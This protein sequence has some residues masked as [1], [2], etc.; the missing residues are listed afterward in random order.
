MG[1]LRQHLQATQGYIELGMFVEAANELECIAPEERV[2]PA[3]L[4]YRYAIYSEMGKWIMAEVVTRQMVKISPEDPVWWVNWAYATRRCQNIEAARQILLDAEKLHPHAA[5]QFNLA[6]YVC[7]IGEMEEAKSRVAAA[8]SLDEKFR[9]MA[10]DDP[11]L[12]PLWDE[13]ANG[14]QVDN[15]QAEEI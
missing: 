11:D 14:L 4:A 12:E 10:L 3:V 5:I 2:H 13:I 1:D 9:L 8:I 7:Q 6:C 15:A